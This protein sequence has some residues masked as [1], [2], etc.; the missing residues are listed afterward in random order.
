MSH[1]MHH[2][3]APQAPMGM[4][5]QQAARNGLGIAAL[6]L[7]LIGLLSGLIPLF[8]WLAGIL[9]LLA[10][11]FGL[12]GLGR[13]K[14]GQATNKGVAITGT[15]F[16]VLALIASAIGLVITVTAVDQAVKE[17][18]KEVDKALEGAEAKP[19]DGGGTSAK[20]YQG[21]ATAVYSTGLNVTVSKP[22][23]YRADEFAVG[24]EQ[25]NK[26]YKVTVRLENKGGKDVSG[27]LVTVEARAGK[28]GK[29]AERIYDGKV[30]SGFGGTLTAGRTATADF[31]F[32]VPAGAKTLD[33]EVKPG[34]DHKGTH[35][36]LTL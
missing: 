5:P 9:G 27:D 28:D 14:R 8:F 15:I 34:F 6:V 33:V 18:N 3:H 11:I 16:G 32:D 29:T 20:G 26:S 19:K 35:W 36:Q 13:A 12:V 7:G 2:P 30:G 10:L 23:P 31:A 17:V 22:S 1:Q 25:G 4:P 21:G 24:H